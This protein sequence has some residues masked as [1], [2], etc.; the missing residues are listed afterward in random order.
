MMKCLLVSGGD[1]Q[2]MKQQ[3]RIFNETNIEIIEHNYK[4]TFVGDFCGKDTLG[5]WCN[6]PIA[7]FYQ[8]FPDVEAGHTHYFGIYNDFEGRTWIT[9]A[10]KMVEEPVWGFYCGDEIVY[11][12]YRNDFQER[13]RTF[14]DGGRDYQ[15]TNTV[16][17][18][19][20]VVKDQLVEV[21]DNEPF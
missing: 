12:A 7:V 8:E 1:I 17:R 10:D 14:V 20:K 3:S 2:E 6:F 9:S 18:P 15:R 4:A 11:S 13:G 21:K 19:F 16:L 5:N